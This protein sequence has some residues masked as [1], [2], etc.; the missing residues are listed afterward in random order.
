ML[1]KRCSRLQPWILERSYRKTRHAPKALGK[2]ACC[3]WCSGQRNLYSVWR[4]VGALIPRGVHTF[5]CSKRC[6]GDRDQK[7][8]AASHGPHT[9]RKDPQYMNWENMGMNG[10]FHP[11]LCPAFAYWPNRHRWASCTNATQ[12]W[13][14]LVVGIYLFL[15]TQHLNSPGLRKLKIPLIFSATFWR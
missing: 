15:A 9:K 10:C 11:S 7:R 8:T 14:G 12:S 5:R 2:D 13:F 4:Q 6:G 1:H 3:H